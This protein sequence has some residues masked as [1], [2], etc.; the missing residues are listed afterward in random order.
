MPGVLSR[1]ACRS[2]MQVSSRCFGSAAA[3]AAAPAMR[4]FSSQSPVLGHLQEKIKKLAESKADQI[5]SAK[6]STAVVGEIQANQ[7][8]G[9]IDKITASL[10]PLSF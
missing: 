1:Y 9:G 3:A 2:G 7:V 5:A 4:Q 10:Y 6:K 8:F